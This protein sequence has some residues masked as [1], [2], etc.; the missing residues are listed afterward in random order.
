M[1]PISTA[2]AADF[3]V[4]RDVDSLDLSQWAGDFGENALSDAD[5]DGDSDGA[6]FLVWQ[7]QFGAGPSAVSAIVAAP[8]PGGV[9]L[10]AIVAC[11]WTSVLEK[12]Q[13]RA[14]HYHIQFRLPDGL[15]RRFEQMHAKDQV[16]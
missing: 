4:D 16:R 14:V 2:F 15:M 13:N 6:D 1:Y 3:D 12:R 5:N 9:V 11:G 10:L 8:E 7:Q